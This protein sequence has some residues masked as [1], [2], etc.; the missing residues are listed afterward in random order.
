MCF[1]CNIESVFSQFGREFDISGS[2]FEFYSVSFRYDDIHDVF[3]S[4]RL[5]VRVC[6]LCVCVCVC[7]CLCVCLC[8]RVYAQANGPSVCSL[9][10]F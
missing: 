5:V 2:N 3:P 10:V 4:F 6:V 7:A 9:V 8:L 1:G